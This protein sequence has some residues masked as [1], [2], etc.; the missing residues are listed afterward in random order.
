MNWAKVISRSRPPRACAGVLYVG[1]D[2]VPLYVATFPQRI[3]HRLRPFPLTY[4]LSAQRPAPYST[5]AQATEQPA[6]QP[7]RTP[8]ERLAK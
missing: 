5:P 1:T 4:T 7:S 2:K 3:N 8:P 6:R